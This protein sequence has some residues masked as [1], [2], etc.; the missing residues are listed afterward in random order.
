L[1]R[2]AGNDRIAD[3]CLD[4]RA[5][6]GDIP[7]RIKWICGVLLDREDLHL[8]AGAAPWVRDIRELA[9]E[10]PQ[11][12]IAPARSEQSSPR[13]ADRRVGSGPTGLV[14]TFPSA[15]V[16]PSSREFPFRFTLPSHFLR[17]YKPTLSTPV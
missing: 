17:T 3:F 2:S 1:T 6:R 11:L 10:Q 16:P 4:D 12:E 7:A 13:L 9:P 8:L 5:F 14:R 15:Q